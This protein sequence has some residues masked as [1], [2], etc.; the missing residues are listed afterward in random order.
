MGG[1]GRLGGVV[2]TA[3]VC[4]R[5]GGVGGGGEGNPFFGAG[6]QDLNRLYLL[7][8]SHREQAS[9]REGVGVGQ[10]VGG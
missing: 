8:D 1:R 3:G 5:G 10:W 4:G 9:K 6:P 7:Y 2:R